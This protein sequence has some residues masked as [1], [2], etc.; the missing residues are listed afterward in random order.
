MTHSITISYASNGAWFRDQ[1]QKFGE[2][3]P[4]AKWRHNARVNKTSLVLS[5]TSKGN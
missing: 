1:V 4:S 3:H 5:A 2:E